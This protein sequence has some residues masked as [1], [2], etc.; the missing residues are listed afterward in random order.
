[1]YP[2]LGDCAIVR[3]YISNNSKCVGY[4]IIVT[5]RHSLFL[6]DMFHTQTVKQREM[7]DRKS[8]LVDKRK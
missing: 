6:E 2:E 1:M 3:K 5:Y 7:L 4:H 8:I